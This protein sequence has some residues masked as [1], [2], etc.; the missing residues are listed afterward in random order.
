MYNVI[1]IVSNNSTKI[2]LKDWGLTNV[3]FKL[4]LSMHSINSF[5]AG[6]IHLGLQRPQ[7]IVTGIAPGLQSTYYGGNIFLANISSN[8]IINFQ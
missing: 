1:L 5:W 2:I 7:N 3:L 4:F 8:S 6:T